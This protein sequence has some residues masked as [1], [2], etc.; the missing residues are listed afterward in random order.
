MNRSNVIV[1]SNLASNSEEGNRRGH[2]R[3]GREGEIA[4]TV[5]ICSF[6]Q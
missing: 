2:R 1:A 4:A 5:S 6:N 3:R